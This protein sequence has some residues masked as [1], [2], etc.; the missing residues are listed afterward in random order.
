WEPHPIG[1]APFMGSRYRRNVDVLGMIV[2]I[3]GSEDQLINEASQG[4]ESWKHEVSFDILDATII[5][6]NFWPPCQD[7]D[8]NIPEPMDHLLGDYAKRYHEIKTPRKLLWKKNLGTVKLELEFEDRTLQFTVIPVHATIIMKLQE[9]TSWTSKSLAAAI[10][11]PVDTLQRRVNFWISKGIVAESSSGGD[12][13]DHLYTLVDSMSDAGKTAVNIE[14]MIADDD[15]ERAVE[16]VEDQLRKEMVVYEVRNSRSKSIAS[17]VNVYNN[18]SSSELAKLTH[19]VNQQTSAVTTAMTAMLKQFQSNPPPAQD[20]VDEEICVTC[21][22]TGNFN[23]D[24]LGYRPQG[25]ANQTRPPGFAQPNVQNNQ[26]R[27]GQPQGF[28]RTTNFNQ[29]QPYQA[30][31]QSNQNFHLNELEKIKRMNDVRLKTMQNQIDMMKNELRNETETSIQTSLS[32]QNNE[33]KNM[34]ASLLQINTASTLGLGTL[35]GITIANPKGELKA[36]TTRSKLVTNGPTIPNPLKYVNPEEDECVKDGPRSHGVHHQG[37]TTSSSPKP[38]P[39]IQRNFVLHTRDSLPP[40]IPYPSRMLKQKDQEKDDIQIQKDLRKFLIPCG[41]SELKCKAL[42]NLGASINLMPLSVWKKLGL[43]D[44]ILTQI[45]LELANRAICTPDGIARDVFVSVGKFTFPADFVVVDYESDPKVPLILGRPFLRTAHALIDVNGEEMILHDGDEMLT[46]NMKHDTTSYSNHPHRESVNLIN[47]FNI[48]SEDCLED[49]VSNKLSGNPTFS[50][51]KEIAS[52]EVIHE[53]HDSKGF[54]FLSKELPDI[55]SFNDIHSYFDDYPLSGSTTFSANSLLEEFTDELDLI[56]YPLNYDDTRACDI[57]SD[58]REIEFLLYQKMFIDEQPPVYSFSP[59]FDVYP[60]DFL[61]IEFDATFDDS[62]DS[63]GEKIKEDDV[64]PSPDNEENVFNPRILSYEKSVKIITRFTQEKKLAVSYASLLFEDFDPPF[65]ELLVFKEVS[66][67]MRLLPFSSE[68]KEKVFKPGI[69]TSKKFHCCFLS[70]LSHSGFSCFQSKSNFLKP[71]EDFSCL[72]WKEYSSLGCS[73]V[74]FLSPLIRSKSRWDTTRGKLFAILDILIRTGK[75]NIPTARPQPVPTGKPKVFARV[76]IGRQNRPFLVPTDRG[77]SSS[78]ISGWWKNGQ[79][80]LSPQQVVLGNHIEKEN[81]FLDAKD[82]GVF[83]SGC[84][85]S[86]T[87]NKERMNDFQICDKKNGVLF[88]DTKCLVLSKDFKL[89]GESIVVL[90][91]PRKHNLYTI[92][93]NNLCPRGNLACLVANA[94]VDEYVKWHRRMGHVNYK[95]MNKLVKGNLVRGLPPKLFNNDHTCVACCKGKQH[96][97]CYKAINATEAVRTACY[98]LN[99][100]L[101]TSPHNKTP[102]ALLTGNIPS[103]SHF[104][105]FECHVTILNTSDHLG[106]FDGKANE[107]Y[108]VGYSASYKHDKANQSAGP[109]KATT[110]PAG[111]KPKDTSGDEVDDSLLN[112]ADKIFQKELARLKGTSKKSKCKI[113]PPGSIPVLTGSI[114]VPDG[115]TMVSTDDV[116]V[117]TSSSTDSFLTISL[118]KDSPVHQTLEI[119]IPHLEEMQQFKFQNVWVL[120]DLPEGKYAIGTKWILKNKK[121]A[122]GIVVQNKARLVAQGHRQEDGIDYNDVFALVVRIEEIR[123]FFAFSSYMGFMVYRMDVKSA[124]PYGRIDEEAWCDEF[125]ALMKGEFQMSAIGELNFFLESV[126]TATTPYGA[127]KAKSK[128]ESDS[129]VNV[130]LYRSMIGLLMYLTAS[131]PDIMFAVCA[132]SKIQ[133]TPNTSNLEAV[134]KIFKYLKGQPKLGLWRLILWKCKKQTIVATSST[135]AEYVA[136]QLLWSGT[137]DT[138]SVVRLWPNSSRGWI[139]DFQ[140]LYMD[141]SNKNALSVTELPVRRW[142][143]EYK[144]FLEAA[145]HEGKDKLPFI[146]DYMAHNDDTSV[147]FEIIMTRDQMN[148]ARHEGFSKKFKLTTTLSTSNMHLFD[149][150]AVIK[151]ISFTSVLTFMKRGGQLREPGK[152][153]LLLENKVRFIREV[154]E[155]MIVVSN[156]KKDDLYAELKVKGFTPLPKETVLEASIAGAVDHVGR[157]ETEEEEEVA[158]GEKKPQGNASKAVPRTEYDYFLSMAIASLTYEKMQK[159]QQERDAKKKE[160][161][162][163][164]NTLSKSL[165]LRD[166]DALDHQLDE[167]DKRDAKDEEE[168]RKQQEKARAKDPG[169]GR[170]AR[171]PARKPAAKK[172]TATPIDAEPMETSRSSTMET[173]FCNIVKLINHFYFVNC[174]LQIIPTNTHSREVQDDEVELLCKAL[175]EISL[176]KQYQ[177]KCLSMLVNSL[178]LCQDN[179]IS[180]E[181]NLLHVEKVLFSKYRLIVSSVL[182]TTL[183]HQFTDPPPSINLLRSHHFSGETPGCH[184]LHNHHITTADPP[185]SPHRLHHPATNTATIITTSDLHQ[186]TPSKRSHHHRHQPPPKQHHTTP[187]HLHAATTSTS[188]SSSSYH[189]HHLLTVTTISSTAAQR[190]SPRHHIHHHHAPLPRQPPW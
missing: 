159:L 132:C 23:Q 72:K 88:I 54:T 13:N 93:L 166:L 153:S 70:K 180:M 121:D 172:A 137:L 146:K 85:R 131:R 42:A 177:E 95:N 6:S 45:T 2:S 21:G 80:R 154:V 187:S 171:K 41:F 107:V 143:Q 64:L 66:N 119:M 106:K 33:I 133:V 78:V 19:A 186:P 26:N 181:G 61:E 160:F 11:L 149:A 59:R 37:P 135:D 91:V 164:T 92:N 165:W 189:H 168:R 108:I 86:M 81:P 52:P 90:R 94:S 118:Q 97:A 5:S 71:D 147:H 140:V 104:K 110:N 67:S 126:R 53:I 7:E 76:P 96:K 125:E 98:V 17:P 173:E 62:F 69:Y 175:E 114:S 34:M 103:A 155:G 83:D 183:P 79:L 36:I 75:V 15:A 148:T 117:H 18:H 100:V 89:P 188:S 123:L 179:N 105:P 182:M 3:I 82:K 184:P 87:D 28:N 25:V 111:T 134:K 162:E 113:V 65:Y 50:L 57:E 185:S 43:P 20:K 58:I 55:D 163:L 77:Y 129:P 161:D 136:A 102:Y 101:V 178:Q 139:S 60:D 138:K 22:A 152:A 56:S 150:N 144:E 130:H 169:G 39:P 38:K 176:E 63:E 84:S 141:Q 32:N 1:A 40:H 167:Q 74:P 122:R 14:E 30:T 51:H 127:P 49:L 170:K 158:A 68:N 31:T 142:T 145:A 29:E 46:L 12:S 128:N 48:L 120:V 116:P 10:G 112:F 124:F 24:N 174:Y 73:S 109:Q 99:R 157:E 47:I 156:K 151:K 8:V 16:S 44:L 115:D 35:P 27:F 190:T 9:Q 4:A